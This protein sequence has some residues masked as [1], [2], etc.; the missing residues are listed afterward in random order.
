MS[1][2]FPDDEPAPKIGAPLRLSAAR[3]KMLDAESRALLYQGASISQLATLFILDNRTVSLRIQG[4]E[5]TGMRAGF[6][7]YKIVDAAAYL[8]KPIQNVEEFIMKMDPE[9]LPPRLNQRLYAGLRERNRYL[10]EIGDL[11]ET[12]D[13]LAHF[14]SVFKTLRMELE[15]LQ[16]AVQEQT[17]FTDRQREILS[18]LIDATLSKA[19][20]SLTE[21]FK[22]ADAA[23]DG[24]APNAAPLAGGAVQ[25][26][27]AGFDDDPFFAIHD[28][29]GDEEAL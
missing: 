4:L 21:Q 10:T 29:A 28:R 7:V 23:E 16:D 19:R 13:V 18:S 14:S 2:D 25:E 20:T 12:G 22:R 11:W 3:Q 26:E 6:P 9:D 17:A 8:V 15:L 1:N 27:Q 24:Q 5:P